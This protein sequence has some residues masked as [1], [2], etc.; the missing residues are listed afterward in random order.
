[1][2][3]S[4]DLRE[5]RLRDAV[6][7]IMV[8]GLAVAALDDITTDK[9][10]SLAFERIALGGCAAWFAFLAWRLIRHGHRTLGGLSLAVVAIGAMVQ[11]GVGPGPAPMW[12]KYVAYGATVGALAWFVALA[13]LL[14]WSAWRMKR[15]S[16]DEGTS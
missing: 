10:A 15:P 13:G 5:L 7:T 4:W 8:V 6:V 11:P 3:T 1:M 9:D 16:F 2:T 14:T 12:F